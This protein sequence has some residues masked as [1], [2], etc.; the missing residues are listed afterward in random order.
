ML[1]PP[2]DGTGT[3]LQPGRSRPIPAA[4]C[5]VALSTPGGAA[6]HGVPRQHP[7]TDACSPAAPRPRYPDQPATDQAPRCPPSTPGTSP[8]SHY[9]D[10]AG[11]V[12]SGHHM[13]PN[14]SGSGRPV[15]RPR[16]RP[17]EASSPAR[18]TGTLRHLRAIRVILNSMLLLALMYTVTLTKSLLIPLVLAAFL[19]LALNPI[20]RAGPRRGPAALARTDA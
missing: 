5:Q 17:E 14:P 12:R 4:R 11:S 1:P 19:G 8:V 3:L 10:R 20:P 2:P 13:W 16:A 6:E 15:D 18:V 9:T 7:S